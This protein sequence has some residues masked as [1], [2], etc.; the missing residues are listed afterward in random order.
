MFE[1]FSIASLFVS[2]CDLY[3]G[4]RDVLVGDQMRGHCVSLPPPFRFIWPLRFSTWR[5]LSR[6]LWPLRL[7]AYYMLCVQ[8][9]DAYC[10]WTQCSAMHL[11]R[12]FQGETAISAEFQHWPDSHE[13]R[14]GSGKSHVQ[15]VSPRLEIK[16][17]RRI[18]SRRAVSRSSQATCAIREAQTGR[19]E[20]SIH[21]GRSAIRKL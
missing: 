12:R 19:F 8:S 13:Q 14:F 4:I 18:R 15:I 6:L 7:H 1:N 5:Y 17:A 11:P 9:A 16:T 20:Q 3:D 2:I 21:L 10:S